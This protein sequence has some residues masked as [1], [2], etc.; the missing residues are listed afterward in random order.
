MTKGDRVETEYKGQTVLG[1]VLRVL[2]GAAKV[3]ID[4]GKITLRGPATAFRPTDVPAPRDPP[5]PADR[6]AV[7]GYRQIRGHGD[8]PTFHAWL[9]LDGRR[10]L[11]A[12][13]DGRGGCNE[14]RGDVEVQRRLH[15]DMTAWSEAL[16]PGALT[17][18]QADT[19]L[20][21]YAT[22]RPYGVLA[23][24]MLEEF[25]DSMAAMHEHRAAAERRA[26]DER[27]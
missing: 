5:T 10:V 13:N 8:S 18:E 1:T 6:W 25:R 11:E 12:M 16:C 9:T 22:Q 21:W 27:A 23:R 2:N 26:D 20:D 17:F 7:D 24:T 3:A 14:Y 4:G 19:W 15:D